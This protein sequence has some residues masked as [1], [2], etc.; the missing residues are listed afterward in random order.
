M[1]FRQKITLYLLLYIVLNSAV[2]AQVVDI[3]DPKLRAAIADALNIAHDAAITDTAMRRLTKLLASDMGILDLSGLEYATNLTVLSLWGNPLV[4]LAP[5]A[6][7][8]R[9]E[10]LDIAACSISDITALS[11]LVSLTIL[12]ARY[13]RI[14]DITPLASLTNLIDLRL[15]HNW[16]TD[17]TALANLTRLESLEIQHN[18]IANYSPLDQLTLSHFT[19]DQFCEMPA[20]PLQ[21]RLE[22][23]TYPSI[24]A[25]WSGFGWPPVSNR[26]ALSGAE[27]IALHDLWFSVAVFG[28]RFR[29]VPNGFTMSGNVD[30]AIRQRNELVSLNP[31]IVVLMTLDMRTADLNDFPDD[32]PYWI[33]DTH[34]NIFREVDDG[35]VANHGLIDFTHPDI[36]HRIVQ[37]AVAVSKCGLYDGIFF[38][39]WNETLPILSSWDGNK[40]WVFRG[41]EAE[42]RARDNILRGIRAETRPNFLIM[43][44]TNNGVIPRTAPHING[45]FKESVLPYTDTGVSLNKSVI[46]VENS[47]KWLDTNLREPRVNALEGW[48]IPSDPPDSPTNLRWMR[49][50]TTLSL[51]HSDGYVVFTEPHKWTHY[52]YD[53]WDADLGS[54]VSPKV[55]LYQETD[56]LYIRE[57]T[58]GWAVYNQQW[59]ATGHHVAGGGAGVAS[60]L[61]NTEHA[62]PNLDGEMYLRV[63]PKNPADVNGDGVVNILDLTLVAQGFGTGAAGVDVNG[64]GVVNVFDLVFVANQF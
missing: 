61:V 28:V 55:Q 3:P 13:N 49:A 8:E 59:R 52:W 36:Q 4:D 53:F 12:N 32:W 50:F 24:V 19:Y 45:G 48:A 34:G 27:N 41:L 6:K 40:S 39:W 57:F 47:L 38:D 23:R 10:Y 5:I 62:L 46:K 18:K 7:L 42:Q 29:E 31:N 15:N 17:V 11:N 33:R 25:R 2:F 58:N 16:I 9:L 37:Q 26:P 43:G 1:K 20:I 30:E 14:V 63:K 54:P 21:P 51:T 44:N 35:Q 56:G 22:N 64:D 60:G